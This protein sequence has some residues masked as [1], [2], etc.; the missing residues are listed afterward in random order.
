MT[1]DLSVRPGLPEDAAAIARIQLG[2]MRRMVAEVAGE[3]SA[4]VASLP[5]LEAMAAQWGQI[6][7][8]PSPDGC[9]TLVA[10]H[11]HEVVGFASCSPAAEVSA[12]FTATRAGSATD[13]ADV[14]GG[15]S[16]RT[17]PGGCGIDNLVID[18]DFLRAGHAS[19]LIAALSDITGAEVFQM[20]VWEADEPRIR[21]LSS[22]GFGPAGVRRG[23]TMSE[24][25]VL[26]E[27][28]WWSKK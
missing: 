13:E 9:H 21:F 25:Q 15:D 17:I 2:Y 16:G 19:R 8:V 27:H 6:L 12:A 26:V 28:L 23:L 10:L 1:A 14:A 11:G 4:A 22:C 18:P 20:W 3:D 7:S 24:D 5:P